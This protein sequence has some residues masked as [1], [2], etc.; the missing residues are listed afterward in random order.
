MFVPRKQSSKRRMR[1]QSDSVDT[2]DKVQNQTPTQT[3]KASS[4]GPMLPR[5]GTSKPFRSRLRP[6]PET[7]GY[8][9]PDSVTS[10][11]AS[12]SRYSSQELEN[13]R[14]GT[15]SV[16]SLPIITATAS[17]KD[18]HNTETVI[19][20]AKRTSSDDNVR[21]ASV[22]HDAVAVDDDPPPPTPA[23]R[24]ESFID[25]KSRTIYR[26]ASTAE[27]FTKQW[28]LFG[29]RDDSLTDRELG[30]ENDVPVV[31]AGKSAKSSEQLDGSSDSEQAR[32]D[33]LWQRELLQRA[34]I[35]ATT[36]SRLA[37]SER[38][39]QDEEVIRGTDLFGYVGL[40]DSTLQTMV[41]DMEGRRETALKDVDGNREK[42]EQIQHA[43]DVCQ[44]KV[45]EARELENKEMERANFYREL[46]GDVE[47]LCREMCKYR[48]Q[49][50]SVRKGRI[51]K[52]R[53][54]GEAVEEFLHNGVDEYGRVRRAGSGARWI[55]YV[56]NESA[57]VDKEVQ[58]IVKDMPVGLRSVCDVI[59]RVTR[60]KEVFGKDYEQI[61][62]DVGTGRLVGA[63]ATC[64][65]SI[66]WVV[67]LNECQLRTALK[68][69]GGTEE[70]EMFV[71]AEWRPSDKGSCERIGKIVGC[72]T[73]VMDERERKTVMD[74]V[75]RRL[76]LEVSACDTS[77]DKSWRKDVEN[78][79]SVLSRWVEIGDIDSAMDRSG[80]SE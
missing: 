64:E 62:G 61:L 32:E 52:Q 41:A 10:N 54:Q 5:A 77:G 76:D 25:K 16:A 74:V 1:T 42:S 67:D 24:N 12:T 23:R 31:V 55:E 59:K 40:D 73:S 2:G 68:V 28:D 46:Q 11:K 45:E 44:S 21:P 63:V 69:C 34:G 72:V 80:V 70:I 78:G 66:D 37:Q 29:D 33:N 9:K 51:E 19:V 22:Q 39:R 35:S 65:Q 53:K 15:A 79:V 27:P 48:K 47:S 20:P 38:D 43:I 60:W 6:T 71:R 13:L 4:S 57:D 30:D 75:K 50:L 14:L 26:S 49:M 58:E 3:L 7:P 17:Q 18:H 56:N 8:E 36:A